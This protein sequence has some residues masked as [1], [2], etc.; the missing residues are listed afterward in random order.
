MVMSL[1]C[2]S[3]RVRLAMYFV[4]A[5][6]S[7]LITAALLD[8]IG[9]LGITVRHFSRLRCLGLAI[10]ILG[11]ALSI[12]ERVQGGNISWQVELSMPYLLYSNSEC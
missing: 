3:W 11:C 5:V 2:T 4:S 8:H 12:V 9:F 10:V 7:Q 1:I 6:T